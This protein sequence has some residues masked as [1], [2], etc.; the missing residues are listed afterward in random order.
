MPPFLK[1]RRLTDQTEFFLNIDNVESIELTAMPD[2][3]PYLKIVR[4]QGPGDIHIIDDGQLHLF[5]L[6]RLR[7]YDEQR[8]SSPNLDSQ[9]ADLGRP[10]LTQNPP[11]IVG[12]DDPAA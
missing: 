4:I 2:G 1:A 11:A 5:E 10:V 12:E 6:Y 9:P 3:M 7:S 8:E